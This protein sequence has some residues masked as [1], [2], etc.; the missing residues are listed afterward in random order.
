MLAISANKKT[1]I[2]YA[3]SMRTCIFENRVRVG[4][5]A[6]DFSDHPLLKHVLY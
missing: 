3:D 2:Y 5:V 1:N 6:M 4:I